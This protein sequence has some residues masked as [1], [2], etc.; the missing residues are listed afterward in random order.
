MTG[1]VQNRARL[2]MGFLDGADLRTD[3]VGHGYVPYYWDIA[4]ELRGGPHRNELAVVEIGT[5]NGDGLHMFAGLFAAEWGVR[6]VGVDTN[7]ASTNAYGPM[8]HASQDDPDLP[9]LIEVAAQ[10]RWLDLVVDDA[11]HL[12]GPTFAAW[13]NL[14]DMVR[15]GG[16]YVV[17]DWN[18]AGM[19][20][21]GFTWLL[22]RACY[23]ED[24]LDPTV[25]S[26]TIRPGLIILR[27][28]A[29]D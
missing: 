18:H 7:K 4:Q 6:I 16:F 27:K 11:S 24:Q 10:Q 14:W 3:K 17:E 25:E 22:I 28:K 5:A 19:I 1:D 9:E 12:E 20:S 8:L 2:I 26:I 29:A 15:P 13:A 23:Q 21:G